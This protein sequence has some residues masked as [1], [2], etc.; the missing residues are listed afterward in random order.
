ML[1]KLF[2]DLFHDLTPLFYVSEFTTAEHYSN[3][4]LVLVGQKA[5]CLF[6]LEVDVVLSSFG[7]NANLFQLRLMAFAFLGLL[8]L[9]VFPLAVVHDAANWRSGLRCHFYQIQTFISGQPD[10]VCGRHYTQLG[11]LCRNDSNWRNT[12]LII[13]SCLNAIDCCHLSCGRLFDCPQWANF[14]TVRPNRNPESIF[15]AT[16]YRQLE[17][18]KILDSVE[19]SNLSYKTSYDGRW[20]PIYKGFCGYSSELQSWSSCPD[21]AIDRLE[22]SGFEKYPGISRAEFPFAKGRARENA[23]RPGLR[24]AGASWVHVDKPF[25]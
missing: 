11:S 10:G 12:N 13:D 4:N 5:N 23:R 15:K 1:F 21:R 7:T 19:T 18:A 14:Q 6:H 17:Q 16:R 8:A 22:Q 9:V 25:D 3:L 2:D 20:A 24:N